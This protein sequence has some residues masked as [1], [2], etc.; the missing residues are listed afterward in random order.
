[1][2]SRRFLLA[3]PLLIIAPAVLL[4][5][6]APASLRAEDTPDVPNAK[7]N[8]MGE[9]TG[10][11]FVRSGPSDNYYPTTKLEKGQKVKVVGIKYQ[12]LKI[13]PPA[14]SFSY[15]GKAFV[16]RHGDGKSGRVNNPANVRAGSALNQMKTTIQTKLDPGAEVKILGEEDEYYKIEPPAGAYV[17]INQQYVRPIGPPEGIAA[18]PA[19]TTDAQANTA[20]AAAGAQVESA[21]K[22]SAD[23]IALAATDAAGGATQPIDTAA[24]GNAGTV[25]APPPSP[26]PAPAPERVAAADSKFE[27]LENEFAA[28]SQKSVIE[29]PIADLLG[30]YQQVTHEEALPESLKRVA[31]ARVAALKVRQEAREQ[32]LSTRKAQDEMRQRNQALQAEREELEE[33]IKETQVDFYTAVGTLRP[34]SLQGGPRG[35]TLYRLTDPQT[36]RTL[37]YLRVA[38]PQAGPLLNQ[39]VGVRGEMQKDP[40]LRINVIQPTETKAIDQARLGN[41]IA[42]AVMPPSLLGKMPT[43]SN[44]AQNAPVEGQ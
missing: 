24:P 17:Y 18:N 25:T 8:F 30:R 11:V 28:A 27:Q 31:D 6:A 12:W 3:A 23:A 21:T 29:Q 39:F 32:F 16:D 42:A 13:E 34:S 5:L 41:G 43:V 44:E 10:S 1:M 26:A 35:T 7:F 36:G 9:T 40:L 14:E 33:K 19:N 22:Q 37:V 4:V 2:A 20:P 38:G 15:V